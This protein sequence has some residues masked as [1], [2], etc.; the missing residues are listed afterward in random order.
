MTFP[1]SSEYTVL[2]P[3]YSLILNSI[4]KNKIN[5]V[6]SFK[7]L[8]TWHSFWFLSRRKSGVCK[9]FIGLKFMFEINDRANEAV[10][11]NREQMLRLIS[12]KITFLLASQSFYDVY[13]KPSSS[14]PSQS[15]STS[16]LSRVKNNICLT[17][18]SL[19]RL[20]FED[21]DTGTT[22]HIYNNQ[23]S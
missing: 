21:C 4:N 9:W 17:D 8:W 20:P 23:T 12:L 10:C 18:K 22:N 11:M 19:E 16:L 2:E 13:I 3:N 1:L 6:T 14:Y 15:Y 7:C 5:Q